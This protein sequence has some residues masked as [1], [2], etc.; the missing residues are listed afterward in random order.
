MASGGAP[1]D[2]E[3]LVI[4]R[5]GPKHRRVYSA[6][7]VAEDWPYQD[8]G[9]RRT[10]GSIFAY[11]PSPADRHR[12]ESLVARVLVYDEQHAADLAEAS[13]RVRATGV[14]CHHLGCDRRSVRAIR[15]EYD[16]VPTLGC[17]EHW[18]G[19]E[20]V[21]GLGQRIDYHV[22]TTVC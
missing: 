14:E 3:E 4:C 21:A 15:G 8:T 20:K 7:E 13:R 12:L 18:R 16:R 10:L 9:E 17:E 19:L 11:F 6:H 22:S 2:S 1:V 5:G